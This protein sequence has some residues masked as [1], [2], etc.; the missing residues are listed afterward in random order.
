MHDPITTVDAES[1]EKNVND[2]YKTMH[3]SV[4]FFAG[5]LRNSFPLMISSESVPVT[6]LV[7]K[8]TL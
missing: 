6:F 7:A 3:K 1:L 2:A 5:N 4:K 8:C